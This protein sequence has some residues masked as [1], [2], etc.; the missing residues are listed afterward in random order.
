MM[1]GASKGGKKPTLCIHIIY[2]M[3]KVGG[4]MGAMM[5]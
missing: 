4:G 5:V 1:P 3:I 2:V